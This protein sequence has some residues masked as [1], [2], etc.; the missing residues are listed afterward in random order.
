[1]LAA[2]L[3]PR[4]AVRFLA[5]FFAPRL[6]VR[7]FA[8]FLRVAFFRVV[9]FAALRRVA[10]FAVRFLAAFFRVAFFAVFFRVAFFA[11]RFFAAPRF[12][13]R[14]FAVR[15]FAAFFVAME[16]PWGVELFSES[17]RTRERSRRRPCP[18]RSSVGI[19]KIKLFSRRAIPP[20]HRTAGGASGCAGLP[21]HRVPSGRTVVAVGADPDRSD[22]PAHPQP[23][24]EMR[25]VVKPAPEAGLQ[26]TEVPEPRPGARD[27]LIRV[28]AAGV[29]GTDLHIWEWD[30]WAA[31]RLRPPVVVGHEFAG[32]V[33]AL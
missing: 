10:F 30:S 32:E 21:H 22:I 33:V 19:Y 6:A 3:A 27:V 12:A 24:S 4:L 5:A 7:F 14:F 28:H 29:C 16:P 17:R 8:A 23:G 31:G 13:V 15:F 11:V 1:F 26:V 20:D 9:F 2:F 18:A 25:A